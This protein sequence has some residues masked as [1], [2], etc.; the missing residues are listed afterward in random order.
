MKL[1][2]TTRC[3]RR[4]GLA[5]AA[6]FVVI[7]STAPPG[8]AEE[9]AKPAV[10]SDDAGRSANDASRA[11]RSDTLRD[12][13]DEA[14]AR[15]PEVRAARDR[16]Q[17]QSKVPIQA[18]TLP[19]PQASL[20]HFT[21]GSPQPFAGY[22]TSDFY[23][24]GFGVSQDIPG[25]GKLRLQRAT[26]EQDA[27][28]A[29][30]RYE[31]ARREVAERVKEVYF[32]L[33]YHG[34]TL[35]LLDR[36]QDDLK[37]IAQVA[38]ARYRLGQVQ[39][40][41]VIKAQLQST[42]ILKEH[43]MHHQ[44]EDQEQLEL[45]RI[46]GRDP[47]SPN[48]AIGEV[49][50]SAPLTGPAE[51]AQLAAGGSPEV[52]ADR[53]MEARGAQALK[54][55]HRGYW[56]DFTA[57]YA[58]QK[59]GPGFRDYYMLS[60]GAKIPLYFW[61]K[62]TPAIEQAAFEA[63]AAR[64]QARATRLRVAAD[65]ESDLVAMRTTERIMGI[66]RDGLIPQAEASQAAATVA[67]RTGKADFQTVLTALIDLRNLREEYYRSLADHEIAAAKLEQIIGDGR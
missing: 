18:A 43:A 65:A 30:H 33:F 6:L 40:Q 19:D 37:L 61:R 46:L 59:T 8:R 28:Y 39:L 55:A 9:T 21:V 51:V 2:R 25:P 42:E 52:A 4:R 14:L 34:R 32:E 45:K 16:W 49:E 24:T 17:A 54:L 58:Y 26:A 56:P 12:L 35:A 60:L 13:I 15:N 57:G 31:A 20:Q 11:V 63:E 62:Q 66:Y 36:N 67:Y 48:I 1:L 29:R 41:D 64:E 7:L 23:Y 38:E 22:E 10:R 44:E 27:E 53:A 3:S 47:D 50:P 5:V